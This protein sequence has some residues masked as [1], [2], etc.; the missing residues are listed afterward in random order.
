V[1]P[2][3][4]TKS[5][6]LQA[7]IQGDSYGLEIIERV[8]KM[9]QGKLKLKQGRVYPV[10]RAMESGGLVESYD[11]DPLP[12]RGGRPRRYYRITA[13]GRRVAKEDARIAVGLFKP[14]LGVA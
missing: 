9:T 8:A 4:D 11:G 1:A 7:L 14:A 12:E 5:A 10:L 13:D 6:L 3:V 2:I